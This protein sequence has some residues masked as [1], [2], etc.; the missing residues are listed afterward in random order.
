MVAR[1]PARVGTACWS[2]WPRSPAAR[3]DPA[4]RGRARP[5][6]R[7]VAAAR[8]RARRWPAPACR[9]A[10][11][12]P[13]ATAAAAPRARASRPRR[14]RPASASRRTVLLAT[15]GA[16]VAAAAIAGAGRWVVQVRLRGT[17]ITLPDRGRQGRRRCRRPGAEGRRDHGLPH[18]QR[19]LLPRRHPLT[20]PAIDVDSALTID[21]DVDKEVDTVLRRPRRDAA[22][23]ARHHPH[24]RLQRR[25]R[26]VHRRRPL[27]RR[28]PQG[29]AR[30][31]RRRQHRRR[32]DPVHRRRRH[33]HPRAARGRHWTAATPCSPS[34]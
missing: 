17:D 32:P 22:R 9:A 10:A 24:L 18:P 20:V 15:G 27:A 4:Q 5:G 6:A 8:R 13:T 21:G 28:T 16:A 14:R 33:D 26:A 30:Q 29:R 34:A 7:A 31:G 25:R 23:R 2:C 11:P 12:R 1:P 3:A 19:R